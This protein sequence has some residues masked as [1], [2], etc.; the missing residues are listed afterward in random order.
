MRGRATRW[1]H[2]ALPEKLRPPGARPGN[3]AVAP[4]KK[5]QCTFRRTPARNAAPRDS[6]LIPAR[7]WRRRAPAK[8]RALRPRGPRAQRDP[9]EAATDLSFAEILK[10]VRAGF[11]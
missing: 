2:R 11:F 1:D 7:Q 4:Q 6:T 5:P 3:Q 9:A 10:G 8:A